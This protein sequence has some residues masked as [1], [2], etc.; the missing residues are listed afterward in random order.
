[1][2]V[3]NL[4]VTVHRLLARP[5]DVEAGVE[6]AL[7]SV[8]ERFPGRPL[9]IFSSLTEG[10]DRIVA[11]RVLMREAASLVAVLPMPQRQYVADFLTPE[12]LDEFSKLVEAADDIVVLPPKDTRARCYEQAGLYMLDHC[13]VL[14]AVW[15]GLPSRGRGGTADIVASAAARHVPVLW[16][17]TDPA[18]P[19]GATSSWL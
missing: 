9:R 5:Q 2:S 10:A 19:G 6:R 8:E 17:R 4:G 7:L 16:I 15:D 3:L 1:V 11:K 12:S 14:I 13:E 18:A